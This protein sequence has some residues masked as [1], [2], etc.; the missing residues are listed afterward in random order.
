MVQ[1]T[2]SFGKAL[3]KGVPVAGC[4]AVGRRVPTV[5]AASVLTDEATGRGG[6]L[7]RPAPV[8]PVVVNLPISLVVSFT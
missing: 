2:V 3:E 7:L 6:R 5:L 4:G 1:L 8:A